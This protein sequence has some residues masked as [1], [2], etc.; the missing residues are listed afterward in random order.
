MIK[1]VFFVV[2]VLEGNSSRPHV[3][4]AGSLIKVKS[5]KPRRLIESFTYSTLWVISVCYFFV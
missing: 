2:F 1:C 5:Q 4:Q 3:N